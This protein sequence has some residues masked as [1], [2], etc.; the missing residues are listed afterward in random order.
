MKQVITC[1]L[2]AICYSCALS[3]DTTAGKSYTLSGRLVDSLSGEPISYAWITIKDGTS[4]K[5]LYETRAD[6]IGF[7]HMV[8]SSSGN[9][10]LSMATLGYLEFLLN[11]S[12]MDVKTDL[13]IIKLKPL[14]KLLSEVTITAGKKLFASDIDKL[15][16]YAENDITASAGDASD[17]LKRAPL[18][19]VDPE[20]N[21]S[22][23]GSTVKVLLNGKTSSLFHRSI[24]DALKSIP[25]SEISR[26]EIITSPSAKYDGDVSGGIINIITKKNFM[27][28]INGSAS[29]G[30]SNLKNN[31]N[32]NIAYKHNNI[33]F[34]SSVNGNLSFK[35][36]R[37]G[38]YEREDFVFKTYNRQESIVFDHQRGI[39]GSA[40]FDYSW[41]KFHQLHGSIGVNISKDMQR[42]TMSGTIYDSAGQA[43]PFTRAIIYPGKNTGADYYLDYTHN[44]RKKDRMLSLSG[45]LN[46]SRGDSWYVSDLQFKQVQ[47]YVIEKADK[48]NFNTE[49]TFQSDYSTT[50]RK[51]KIEAGVKAIF[52]DFVND[53][54][55][56]NQDPISNQ[57]VLN[58]DRTNLFQFNQNVFSGYLL[59][60]L[61]T[62]SKYSIRIGG[63]TEYTRL[64]TLSDKFQQTPSIRS[65]YI[66]LLPSFAIAR[67]IGSG[68]QVKLSYSKRLQ[69]PGTIYLNPFI[70]A[71]DSYNR[72]AGNPYLKPE[73]L[74]SAELAYSLNH[75]NNFYAFTLFYRITRKVIEMYTTI[76]ND[77]ITVNGQNLTG[78]VSTTTYDN[79]GRSKLSGVNLSISV[80]IM[81]N[82]NLRSNVNLNSY[83]IRVRSGKYHFENSSVKNNVASMNISSSWSLKKTISMEV[84]FTA[85]TPQTNIQGY[86]NGFTLLSIVMRKNILN[87][88]G[89]IGIII[90]EPFRKETKMLSGRKSIQ[91]YEYTRVLTPYRSLAINFRL[92]FGK[93]KA[94]ASSKK[95]NNDDLK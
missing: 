82:W 50:M 11:L 92:N 87:N 32:F 21:I 12:E 35:R 94:K 52:R 44:F 91:F 71:S 62:E 24:K 56:Y 31:G 29:M 55:V 4:Q 69:R 41:N 19:M 7:F 43:K 3:Q 16:Y 20:G 79:I 57:F 39:S 65:D 34:Y 86:N 83:N 27:Q 68:Q 15:I 17:V 23:R 37:P 76:S 61:K 81:E 60:S 9:Y 64:F 10:F 18:V 63:R 73:I 80:A 45:L 36:R 88:A 46:K 26:I 42:G 77:T 13:G 38:Y 66:N 2:G 78:T 54:K 25:A 70:S 67:S 47:E 95:I 8:I 5:Q 30:I 59:Y 48:D 1:L 74:H 75:K 89:S 84:F 85:R 93:L 33:V 49:I 14:A 90:T 58:P 51:S 72:T 53:F 28:G 22:L 6:S 40:G